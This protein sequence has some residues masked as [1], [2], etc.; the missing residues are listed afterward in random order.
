MVSSKDIVKE[1]NERLRDTW[2]D[3]EWKNGKN[4]RI[5][6]EWAGRLKFISERYSLA[7][8]VV[9]KRVE[10]SSNGEKLFFLNF[11]NPMS[12]KD[13]PKEVR[14]TGVTV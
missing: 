9:K 6:K 12:F 11:M 2:T 3:L 7:G 8:W 5:K 13:C 10:I 4:V 1:I 14:A